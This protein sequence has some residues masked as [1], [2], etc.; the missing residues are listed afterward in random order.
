MDACEDE[1]ILLEYLDTQ[2]VSDDQMESLMPAAI[3]D[4][5][6]VPILVCNPDS[7]LGVDEVLAFLQHYSPSPTDLPIRDA[8]GEPL[9]ASPTADLQGTVFNVKSDPHVGKICLV[10]IHSG[11]LKASDLVAAPGESKGEKLGG[12]FRLI[13]KKREAI[14]SAG[15]GDV[16]AF[17]KV[18]NL[19][20]W[21]EF[22]L[23]GGNATTVKKPPTP[24]PM[25]AL[26]VVPKTR[27]DE[28]KL[29]E[30]LKKLA[31]E[32]PTFLI[33]HAQE[34][35]E[36]V[37]H[38]MS[39]LHLQ[40]V[41]DRMKRRYGV[42]VESHIPRIAYQETITKPSE[43]HHR[44]RKQSGGRGQFGE[45]YVR[46]RPLAAGEGI[47][48]KDSVVGGSIP[49]NLIPAVEKGIIEIAGEGILTRG[50]VVDLEVELYDGKFHAVDSDEA[51][52]KMAGGR[53]FKE[54][55]MGAKPVLLEP[56][57]ELEI[58]IPSDD[59]GT[60]F[61]DL[62][63]QRRGHVLDQSSE[64][65]GSITIIKVEA[66]L[67]TIQTYHRDLKSQTAGE[68]DYSMTFSRYAPVPAI[69]QPKVLAVYG[70][71]REGV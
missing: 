18:E 13:G 57:M 38:G 59:A 42:E 28:Q 60:V 17:T 12:L 37:V 50:H 35:H 11:T 53:A 32:D 40:V 30:A 8:D 26:A 43:G 62:T 52:F 68:G 21:D 4:G 2:E 29:G 64:A 14:E 36:L 7:G 56:V 22:N 3:A 58:H 67:A 47:V 16:V 15:P 66:P 6:L 23:P 51:S 55:F 25:V 71:D 27:A 34:T 20:T 39:D 46:L 33:E 63:S 9:D 44:H 61:S 5:A 65:D 70:R 24:T 41:L 69:E 49:R 10:R 48:F 1:D 19:T 54:G 31:A 45:C